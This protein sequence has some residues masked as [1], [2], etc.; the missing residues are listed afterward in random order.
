MMKNKLTVNDIALANIRQRK[1]QYLIMIIGIV[2]AMVFSGSIVFFMA[3]AKETSHAE[4]VDNC[5]CQDTVI[6]IPSFGDKDYEKA[7]NSGA[8]DDYA[9]VDILGYAYKNDKFKR[10]GS[11]VGR[12]NDKFRE[13][14][15]QRLL[16]GRLPEAEN[17]I[18]IESEALKKLDYRNASVG[19]T[20]SLKF[21]VQNA[22]GYAQTVDKEY[23]V[24]GI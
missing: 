20:I 11:A 13:I 21:M 10:L 16:E 7:K 24:T 6:D 1:K 8:V 4:Y 15:N 9:I 18:A 23:V 2:L 14:S 19:S 3:A 12:A 5:G 22:Q 17:E